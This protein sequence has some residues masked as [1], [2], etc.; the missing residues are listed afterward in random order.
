MDFKFNHF[1]VF[2]I[3]ISILIS[4][5]VI[6]HRVFRNLKKEYGDIDVSFDFKPVHLEKSSHR[7]D[8]NTRV[9]IS[10]RDID[11]GDHDERS[12]TDDIDKKQNNNSNNNDGND[13]VTKKKAIGLRTTNL[14]S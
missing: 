2:A 5:S 13:E 4:F 14:K 9:E 11:R 12:N 3:S 8:K 7:Y 10:E 1:L 6:A